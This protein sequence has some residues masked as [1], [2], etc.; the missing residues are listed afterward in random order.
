[1]YRYLKQKQKF[2]IQVGFCIG[3]RFSEK[4]LVHLSKQKYLE[5]NGRDQIRKRL[6]I[7]FV[8]IFEQEF[9]FLK[10]LQEFDVFCKKI[11]NFPGTFKWSM[12][13]KF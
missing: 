2:A 11:S 6:W 12:S 4:Y 13:R 10:F 8:W 9:D 7:F 5:S 1:M 3:G